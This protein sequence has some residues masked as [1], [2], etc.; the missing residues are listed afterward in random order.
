MVTLPDTML[1]LVKMA[2][3]FDY[4]TLGVEKMIRQKLVDK[5]TFETDKCGGCRSCE[6]ACSYHHR[7]LFQP[8]ISSME[9]TNRPKELTFDVTFY[10]ESA[11]GRIAC[12]QCKELAVPLCVQV[13]PSLYREELKSLLQM[14][15][16]GGPADEQ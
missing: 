1:L 14:S 7:G 9:I 16:R 2:F 4:S 11:E 10:R 6:L 15:Y 12:D 3:K 8:S 5:V 13:C